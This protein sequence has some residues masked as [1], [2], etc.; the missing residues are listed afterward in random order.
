[1]ENSKK[2]L[3]VPHVYI[4]LLALILICSALSYIIPA[5]QYDMVTLESGR[6]V[7]DSETYHVVESTP[8]SIMQF[9]SAVPRGMTESAQI[10]LL[11]VGH[12]QF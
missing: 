9:L 12:L 7:V 2:K 3:N 6:E 10:I 8:V 4:L 1:M 5:G 11:L